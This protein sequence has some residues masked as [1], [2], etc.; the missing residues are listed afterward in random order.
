[1]KKTFIWIVIIISGFFTSALTA[2]AFY[3][4]MYQ[5]VWGASPWLG[6]GFNNFMPMNNFGFNNFGFNP[7]GFNTWGNNVGISVQTPYGGGALSFPAGHVNRCG[8]GNVYG[9]T[10]PINQGFGVQNNFLNNAY[11][12]PRW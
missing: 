1:M 7:V 9:C 2:T 3:G 6:G 12:G 10:P 4:S 11:F 5:P 8:T